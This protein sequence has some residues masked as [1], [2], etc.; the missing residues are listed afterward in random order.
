MFRA[1]LLEP[2][3]DYTSGRVIA[4]AL[5]AGGNYREF[6]D[7]ADKDKDYDVEIKRHRAHRSLDANAYY[8]VLCGKIADVM[9]LSKAEVKNMTLS[10]YGQLELIDGKPIEY[11]IPD[12]VHVERREDMHLQPTDDVEFNRGTLCRWY[13][14][15]RGSKTL[16]TAEFSRL[17]QGTISDAREAGLTDA[18][19]MT[20]KEKEQLR[21]VYG[22]E[23]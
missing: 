10:A 9:G 11:L 6:Y 2:E 17:I 22:I 12:D 7:A 21:Q 16:D 1:K 3:V 4:R 8:H 14:L 13:R 19:I 5:V 23:V 15:L 20:P 18:E